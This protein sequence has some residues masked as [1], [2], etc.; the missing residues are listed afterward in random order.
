MAPLERQGIAALGA[1]FALIG[2]I[3]IASRVTAVEA[4]A[5]KSP[6]PIAAR[7]HQTAPGRASDR[8]R[9]LATFL[10]GLQRL[11]AND[12]S[13]LPDLRASAQRLCAEHARCDVRD[14][15]AYY[16]A[17]TPESRT[18]GLEEEA[19]LSKLWDD[20][21][22]ARDEDVSSADWKRARA[23]ILAE[24]AAIVDRNRAGPDVV[25]AARA[26]S[27]RARLSL[28][29]AEGDRDLDEEGFAAHL[30]DAER[31]A[32][33]CLALFQRAGQMK[34]RLE[35]LW[36]ECRIQ[37]ARGEHRAAR[38]SLQDCLALARQLSSEDFQ[39]HAIAGLIRLAREAGD[40]KEIER[41]L[42]E[43]SR[44]RS[45]AKS[46]LLVKRQADLLLQRDY[47]REAARFL[48]RFPPTD[49]TEHR[50]WQ[51]MLGAAEMRSGDLAAAQRVYAS[52]ID[53][54][55][56]ADVQLGMASLHLRQ[57]DAVAAMEVLDRLKDVP[58]DQVP[59]AWDLRGGA[60]IR[61][62]EFA[63]AIEPL[64]RALDNA[65]RVQ[66][67]LREQ[68]E[69]ANTIGEQIGVHTL[70]QLARAHMELGQGL[71]AA[72]VMEAYQ[73]LTLRQGVHGAGGALERRELETRDLLDWAA[74]FERGLVTWVV[75]ADF[76]VVA[77][78]APDGRAVAHAIDAGR[79]PIED[80]VRRL[81]EATIAG[82]DADRARFFGEIAAKL[83]PD[84]LRASIA[85][86]DAGGAS[87]AGTGAGRVLLLLHGPLE[88]L[89]VELF[90][91]DGALVDAPLVPVILPGLPERRVGAAFT[92][93]GVEPWSVLGSPLDVDGAPRLPGASAEL[94]EV[95]ALHPNA[96]VA[97]E[98]TFTRDA[99]TRA[100]RSGGAVH[101]ATHLAWDV[102]ERADPLADVGLEL[103]HG[104]ALSADEIARIR[105]RLALAVL[106]ACET[107]GGEFLDSLGLNGV[108]RAFLESGTRNLVVT[109]WPVADAAAREFAVAFH[110]SLNGGARPSEAVAAARKAL[111]DAGFPAVEWAAFRALGRD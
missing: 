85:R 75:G 1:G 79:K 95:A 28:E 49:P 45:P 40:L 25:P 43:L 8:D 91:T 96:D 36:I 13:V 71:E 16:A 46:W 84:A 111:R 44:F 89:P 17:Q 74:R 61:L 35:P 20:V 56:P 39:E 110:A 53:L 58:P 9:E 31:D 5:A 29:R 55:W 19:R 63:K 97:V 83:F 93:G 77:H 98:G 27:L 11:R 52:G 2:V 67:R 54:P 69:A 42:R 94:A 65:T 47:P 6:A 3:W 34:P 102:G 109:S 32:L 108:A 92:A 30:A 50:E 4:S 103:S 73:S 88:R 12:E 99:I 90:E 23:S 37:A 24:L 66:S 87:D 78:V 59:R 38:A 57:G 76:T 10:D 104:E 41:L 86:V 15:L 60:H 33:E 107:G 80:A 7:S 101:V 105:P 14:V 81:R 48:E 100:L 70:A 64:T 72:R 22:R 62:G 106:L 51:L 82:S 26:L 21:R 18:R 68:R